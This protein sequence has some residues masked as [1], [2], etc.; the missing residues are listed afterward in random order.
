MRLLPFKLIFQG[1]KLIFFHEKILATRVEHL[2]DVCDKITCS[3]Y[4][5][6]DKE[7]KYTSGMHYVTVE[8][9][10][11]LKEKKLAIPYFEEREFKVNTD[12]IDPLKFKGF[13]TLS[14]YDVFCF[15]QDQIT[16]VIGKE[17]W[18]NN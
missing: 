7:I 4:E 1:K 10:Q 3:L 14:D 11:E 2:Y 15:I 9:L 16:D 12:N 6:V 13:E 8:E 17:V 5:F 18:H